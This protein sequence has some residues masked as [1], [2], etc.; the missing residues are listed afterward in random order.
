MENAKTGNAAKTRIAVIRVRG[1]VGLHPRVRTAFKTLKL[2]RKN[3]CVIVDNSPSMAGTLKTVKDHTT[4]GELD[5][6]TFV[7]LLQKKAKMPGEAAL[8]E[9]YLKQKLKMDFRQFA[10]SFFEFKKEL[11]DI[12]GVKTFFRLHPPIGGFER[13]GIKRGYAEGG[14]LDYRGKDINKLIERMIA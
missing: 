9:E 10:D 13:G 7:K 3:F 1:D 11:R 4:F 12:P 14:A 6:E 5:K 2:Y 8:T